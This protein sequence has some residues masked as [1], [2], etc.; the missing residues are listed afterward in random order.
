MRNDTVKT[1]ISVVI[2]LV[3]LVIVIKLLNFAVKILFPIAV[4]IIAAYI[5]YMLVRKKY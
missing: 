1:I 2:F 3:L 4:I 5:I